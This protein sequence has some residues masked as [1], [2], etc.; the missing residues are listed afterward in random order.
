MTVYVLWHREPAG[1]DTRQVGISY[2]NGTCPASDHRAFDETGTTV[3]IQVWGRRSREELSVA[4]DTPVPRDRGLTKLLRNRA[5]LDEA[6][7]MTAPDPA[8]RRPPART[9]VSLLNTAQARRESTESSI[10]VAGSRPWTTLRTRP[11]ES[12][13]CQVL[14]DA[15]AAGWER[16]ARRGLVAV[17]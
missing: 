13:L 10:C 4:A 5:V 15:I 6:R 11:I 9:K 1:E 14:L 16:R 2:R 12:S 17:P 3:P 8:P 7:S